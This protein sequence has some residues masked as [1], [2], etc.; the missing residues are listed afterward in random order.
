M[1]PRYSRRLLT[2]VGVAVALVLLLT[3]CAPAATSPAPAPAPAQ[4]APTSAPQAPP[5]GSIAIATA[6]PLPTP[7]TGSPAPV[8]SPSSRTPP[9]ASSAPKKGGILVRPIKNETGTLDPILSITYSTLDQVGPVYD[10][11]LLMD[12]KFQ[13]RPDL[14]TSWSQLDN[15]TY[16]FK[17]R[18]GVRFHNI[19][20]VNGRELTPED[21]KY[22]LERIGFRTKGLKPAARYLE[23]ELLEK[24]EVLD[25]TTV[26]VKLREPFAPFITYVAEAFNGIVPREYADLEATGG[27][28]GRAIGTGPFMLES[29]ARDVQTVLARN[30]NYWERDIP[31]LDKIRVPVIPDIAARMAAFRVRQADFVEPD[32]VEQLR[33]LQKTNPDAQTVRK[34]A[35]MYLLYFN[36]AKPP[37]DDVRVRKALFK[38]IDR[39]QLIDAVAGGDGFVPSVIPQ[40]G[41]SLPEEN[42]GTYY[43][44]DTNEA[45]RLLEAAGY[46]NNLTFEMLG[47]NR[48][49]PASDAMAVLTQQFK[50]IGVT[51]KATVLEHVV[52][53]ER[54]SKKKDYQAMSFAQ[55]IRVDP[56]Q[57]LYLYWVTSGIYNYSDAT[58]DKLAAEQRRET[59]LDKRRQ[60]L[61]QAQRR[62]L[63]EAHAAPLWTS[64]LNEMVQPYVRNYESPTV[65]HQPLL[66]YVSLDK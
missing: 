33:S 18:S 39:K 28:T 29:Y 48:Q 13:V 59:N 6:I 52:F 21:V 9:S 54:Y 7:G 41:W 14:A 19:P 20:P 37:F 65:Y 43:K 44:R 53:N 35:V 55:G 10:T 66:R 4:P 46:K 42:L 17:L 34:P 63:D 64:W 32:N 3:A 45:R 22:T 12:G 61:W 62:I 49:R 27:F 30:P 8:P 60:V 38:A 47:S 36:E 50:E 15:Q 1:V 57:Q 23:F 5:I 2:I 56:D 51:F 24:V 16:V 11:L 26:Q 31:H 40:G 25:R 58:L